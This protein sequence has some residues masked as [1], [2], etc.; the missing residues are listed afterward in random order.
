MA[1][2]IRAGLTAVAAVAVVGGALAAPPGVG[3]AK[4]RPKPRTVDVGDNFFAPAKLTVR[5][6]TKVTWKW[7]TD[8]GD[9]HDVKTAKVPKGAKRF[10][11]PPYAVGARFART[12]TKAGRYKLYCTFHATEMTMTITVRKK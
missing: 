7:P 6:G 11:S 10:A 2:G 8:V 12:F 5:P 3:A 9:S 4:K 1:G